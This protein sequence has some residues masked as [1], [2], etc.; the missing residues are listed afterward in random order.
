MRI[1]RGLAKTRK[2]KKVL[3]STKGYR[4]SNSKLYKR[5]HEAMLHA[6]NYS[7]A[8]RRRRMS[9]MRTLWIQRINAALHEQGMK[10]GEFINL[11]KKKNIELDRKTLSNLAVDFPQTF[12]KVVE[13][14][15]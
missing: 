5:A 14:S 4:L 15:K 10:Y 12:T 13:F 6:G 2:H 3:E 8:H 1:K 9:Q 7:L 11:L